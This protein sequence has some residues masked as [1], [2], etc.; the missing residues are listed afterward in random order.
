MQKKITHLFIALLCALSF[1]SN[2]Q[3][4]YTGSG[5]QD[6]LY[7]TT[8]IDSII[9]EEYDTLTKKLVP[10]DLDKFTY[11]AQCKITKS[12]SKS[13]NVAQKKWID[14]E[15]TI[16][17]YDAQSRLASYQIQVLKGGVW[18]DSA[19]VNYAYTG[20]ATQETSQTT[21]L[22]E[23]AVWKNREL[24]EFTYTATK[25]LET[26]TR[27]D[28]AGS[29]WATNARRTNTYDAQNRLSMLLEEDWDG[30]KWVN[31]SRE[32][33]LYNAQNKLQTVKPEQWNS[34][35][36][37]WE[38]SDLFTF[39]LSPNGR[40]VSLGINFFGIPLNVD[41]LGSATGYLDSVNIYLATTLFS[42][43]RFVYNSACQTTATNDVVFLQNAVSISPNP[44]SENMTIRLNE[45]EG[46]AFS[47]TIF[48]A[49]GIA[50]DA[51]KW[52]GKG[53]QQ[54]DISRLPN[55]LYFLSVKGEKWQAVHKF[56][57]HH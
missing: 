26:E 16:F 55:G 51:L 31:S 1:N 53:D 40:K 20:T 13:W 56:V 57:V 49:S 10:A 2:A 9:A 45:A 43:I 41:Y 17:N 37:K 25:K 32:T 34:T 19:R 42:R 38:T 18:A 15:Q 29:T 8:G 44:T 30:T 23:A 47:A 46:D 52:N 4:E 11:N 54:R 28:W 33:Y 35:T 39:M 21:Q 27:K 7:K 6:F 12:G 36:N 22:L 48:N 24:K 3:V 5:F 50:V 14:Y